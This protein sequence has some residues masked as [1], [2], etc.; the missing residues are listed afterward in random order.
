[1]TRAAAHASF[2]EASHGTLRAGLKADFVLLDRDVMRVPLGAI[3]ETRVRATV[4]DGQVA[5]GGI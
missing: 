5:F 2:A 4:V 1:M 3:L